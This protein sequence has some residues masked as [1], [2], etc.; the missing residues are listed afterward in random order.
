MHGASTGTLLTD[1]GPDQLP[2]SCVLRFA[3]LDLGVDLLLSAVGGI[4]DRGLLFR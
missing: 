3:I 2:E 1:H 4:Q